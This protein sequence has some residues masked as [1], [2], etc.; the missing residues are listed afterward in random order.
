MPFGLVLCI[1]ILPNYAQTNLKGAKI[2]LPISEILTEQKSK[3]ATAT[4]EGISIYNSNIGILLLKSGNFDDAYF[5][6]NAT[7]SPLAQS[8]C[9]RMQAFCK[10]N[11]AYIELI[12]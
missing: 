1:C 5:Y 8:R 10:A 6:F 12:R 9:S 3:L 11:L 7:Y 4:G 2:S